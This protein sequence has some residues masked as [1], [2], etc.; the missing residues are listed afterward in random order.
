MFPPSRKKNCFNAKY[1]YSEPIVYQIINQQG[2]YN[3]GIKKEASLKY[4]Q[5]IKILVALNNKL[6]QIAH[7]MLTR[8]HSG[9]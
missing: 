2:R 8:V 6:R 4:L 7:Q 1:T 5:T 3:S 9:V